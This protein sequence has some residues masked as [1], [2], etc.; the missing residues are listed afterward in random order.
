MMAITA[1]AP[2]NTCSVFCLLSEVAAKAALPTSW[3]ESRGRIGGY[4]HGR[5]VVSLCLVCF[6]LV[7]WIFILRSVTVRKAHIKKDLG[8]HSFRFSC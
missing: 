6:V 2:E 7:N 8:V 1:T 5:E 3:G 4:W